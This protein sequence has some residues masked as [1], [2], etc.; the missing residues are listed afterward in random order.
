MKIID[1][2]EQN[3][4]TF[5]CEIFPPK[6]HIPLDECKSVIKGIA[7]TNPDLALHTVQAAAIPSVPLKLQTIFKH[8][9]KFRRWRILLA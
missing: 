6:P 4:V 5:S 3:S 1:L 8:S 9:I 2:I 7:K